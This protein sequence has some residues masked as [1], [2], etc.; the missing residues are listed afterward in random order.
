MARRFYSAR[1]AEQDG[2]HHISIPTDGGR[3][4]AFP[5]VDG[6][7]EIPDDLATRVIGAHWAPYHGQRPLPE[8]HAEVL[9]EL[10]GPGAV[11]KRAERAAM[12]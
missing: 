2:I 3:A 5:V 7:L 1:L 9:A 4:R 10:R 12:R 6:I 11:E 8:N